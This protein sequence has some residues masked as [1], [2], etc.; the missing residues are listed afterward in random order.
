MVDLVP[1]AQT[2]EDEDGLGHGR[3]V[4]LDRL[5]AAFQSRVLLEVLAVLLEGG[6]T[7]GLELAP[8]QHRLEDAGGVD[9]AFGGT[10][11]DQ[12]VDLVDEEDDV[13]PGA[14]LLQDLLEAL[15]EVTAIAG[16]GHQGTEVE[17]VELLAGEGVG[18]V[19]GDDL[20]GEAFDDGGLADAGLTDEHR[21]VLGAAGQDL[22]DSL[23][24]VAA[25]DDRVE[26]GFAGQL[27][28]V[29][30][31]LIEHRR[32]GA[33]RFAAAASLLATARRGAAARLVFLLNAGEQ[34]DDGLADLVEVGA[35]LLEHLGGHAFALAD[36]AEEDVLGPDVVVSELE[37]LAQRQFEDLLGAGRERNVAAGRLGALAD[38]V[39]DLLAN[40]VE[41]DAHG[42]QGAGG[43]AFA[44]VDEAEKDVLGA[45]VIVV[46]KTS[47]FLGQDNDSASP[48]GESLEHP[49]SS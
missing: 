14:D 13:A 3:L 22:H 25:T 8:G 21:V 4:D 45:D 39:D 46:E 16:P 18:D 26:L 12:G 6:G 11:A 23:D 10:G 43:D 35:E 47:F 24:L 34:L 15:L 28:E 32:P 29:A 1:V 42:L 19:A 7:D 41:A 44:F 48:L 49:R 17:G 30:A 37:G 2:L 27:G 40:G 20:Q 5:E 31:E 36:E 33:G 38:D 9:G